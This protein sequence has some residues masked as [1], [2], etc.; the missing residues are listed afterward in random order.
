MSTRGGAS[1]AVLL[2]AIILFFIFDSVTNRYTIQQQIV[3][4]S[5]P[6]IMI[7]YVYRQGINGPLI[8]FKNR[9]EAISWVKAATILEKGK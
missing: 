4:D 7:Y 8:S 1:L 3:K 5:N 6:P 9:D 2:I